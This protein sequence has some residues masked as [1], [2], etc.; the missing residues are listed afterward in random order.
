ML[1]FKGEAARFRPAAEKEFSEEWDRAG[2]LSL[3]NFWVVA[4]FGAEVV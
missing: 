3:L 2:L 1:G 4:S